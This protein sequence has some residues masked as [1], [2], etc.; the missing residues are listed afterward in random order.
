MK[1]I[2]GDFSPTQVSYLKSSLQKKIV[3]LLIYADPK[4]N[5]K[6]DKHILKPY[7]ESLLKKIGGLNSVLNYPNEIVDIL[8]ILQA[9]YIDCCKHEFVFNNR[10]REFIL[11][12]HALV[13][14]IKEE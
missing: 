3:W 4:T 6:Y 5:F 11:D 9:A 12:A 1:T 7:F 8:S 14:K 10:Y 13:G 2:Y